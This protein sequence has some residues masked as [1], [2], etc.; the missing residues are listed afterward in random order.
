M[1]GNS[2]IVNNLKIKIMSA[3]E[4]NLKVEIYNLRGQNIKNF[5]N[6]IPGNGEKTI[7]WNGKNKS[8]K[9]ISNGVYIIK[10]MAGNSTIV[11]KLTVLNS[12]N[13]I[14]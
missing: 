9:N 14:H 5:N 6:L 11:K 3:Y 10:F 12:S 2:T 8:D 4:Q 1:A 13:R 7:L